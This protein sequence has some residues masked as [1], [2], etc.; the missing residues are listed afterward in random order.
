MHTLSDA[1]KEITNQFDGKVA[2]TFMARVGE[3]AVTRDE[4]PSTHFCVYFAAYDQS[5]GEVFMGHH[6][7]SGLWLFN[8]GHIDKGEIP[9]EAVEREIGEE[10]GIVVSRDS[11][12]KPELLTI[13]DINN[14][15]K[16]TCTKHYDIWY[17]IPLDKSAVFD[18]DKL[19]KEFYETRW[20]PV[21]QV[22]P[23]VTDLSTVKAL[24]YLQGLFQP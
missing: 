13:T 5:A 11:I 4:N 22:V 10:W 19:A 3:G 23:L 18:Q 21:D 1:I 17:F 24:D 16:Q 14:R 7:K 6:K 2:A 12:G 20:M 9:V 8:G 15:P